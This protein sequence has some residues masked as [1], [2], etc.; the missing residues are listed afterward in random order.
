M[1]ICDAFYFY[2]RE[3]INRLINYLILHWSYF[4]YIASLISL[5]I[6]IVKRGGGILES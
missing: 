6:M 5:G 2:V 4:L 1:V 3:S